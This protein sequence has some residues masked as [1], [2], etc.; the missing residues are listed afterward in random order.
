MT[1]T[2]LPALLRYEDR[3]TMRFAVE[4]RLPFLDPRVVEAALSLS[5]ARLFDGAWTKSI[6]REAVSELL[7]ASIVR[8]RD[9]LGFA[10]PEARLLRE[11][12]PVVREVLGES[13]RL[14]GR[15][16]PRFVE[17]QLSLGDRL[18]DQRYLARWCSAAIW[19]RE[20]VAS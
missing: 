6:L 4:A 20:C 11:A 3:N 10:T 9:K 17:E 1:V 2:S 13:G 19:L 16:D 5:S 8:R 14:D 12:L 18:A 7:P 15:L